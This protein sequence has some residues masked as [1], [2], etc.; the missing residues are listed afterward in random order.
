[1]SNKNIRQQTFA[2][3]QTAEENL[4]ETLD[5]YLPTE[6]DGILLAGSQQVEFQKWTKSQILNNLVKDWGMPAD[7]VNAINHYVPYFNDS[8]I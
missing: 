5:K 7:Q 1:M 4:E 6:D 2:A 8:I 3:W